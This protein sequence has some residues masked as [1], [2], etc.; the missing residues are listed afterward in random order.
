M[1]YFV[2]VSKCNSIG[3]SPSAVAEEMGF[4]RSVVTRWGNGT[5]PRR[6]TLQRVADYFHCPVDDFLKDDTEQE[7]LSRSQLEL[8]EIIG[9]QNWFN[10]QI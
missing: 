5:V 3:K 6:A 1:F 4:K 2:Y 8:I 10:S 9:K 7:N